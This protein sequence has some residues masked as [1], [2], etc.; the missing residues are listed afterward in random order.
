MPE[1]IFTPRT[2]IPAKENKWYRLLAGG[3]VSPCIPGR[4]N[5]C[6]DGKS[7]LANCVG[8]SWGRM[9]ELEED[10]AIKVGCYPG[11][12]YPGDAYMW[13]TYS[14][15]QGFKTGV[16]PKLGAVAVWVSNRNKKLGHVANVEKIYDDGSWQSSESGLNT[17]PF[18]WSNKYNSKSYKA[19]YSFKGF[20]YPPTDWKEKEPEP[21]FKKGD[22]VRIIAKGNSQASGKGLPAG[23]V[24][25]VRYV[26]KVHVG[27]AYP[28][29]VGS[30]NGVTTGYYKAE[31]LKKL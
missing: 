14:Q 2:E 20:V 28:Y 22:K 27:A 24:G 10:P 4:P 12:N 5:Y 11:H 13:L 7:A 18:W 29:Q 3:G 19:G 6:D 8:Y 16:T 23:G 26:L 1:G 15:K 21:V 30:L 31:A 9:A 17:T 25:Y